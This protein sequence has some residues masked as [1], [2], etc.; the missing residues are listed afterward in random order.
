MIGPAEPEPPKKCKTHD[1]SSPVQSSQAGASMVKTEKPMHKCPKQDPASSTD[2]SNTGSSSVPAKK[3]S[4]KD[5]KDSSTAPSKSLVKPRGHKPVKPPLVEVT[6]KPHKKAATPPPTILAEDTHV[7]IWGR[8][9]TPVMAEYM[10]DC[11]FTNYLTLSALCIPHRVKCFSSFSFFQVLT[12]YFCLGHC[13]MYYVC[14]ALYALPT[15]GTF[16]HL[17]QLS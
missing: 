14:W 10:L 8:S 7:D 17:C 3:S 13:R 1:P 11:I 6:M 5:Q 2:P 9:P 15:Q 16:G 12:R 4:V